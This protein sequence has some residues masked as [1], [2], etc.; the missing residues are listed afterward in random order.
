MVVGQ[1]WLIF[2]VLDKTVTPMNRLID[3]TGVLESSKA[4]VG[5]L[6]SRNQVIERRSLSPAMDR[7]DD[8][9]LMP[10]NLRISC[11][12]CRCFSRAL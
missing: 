11:T 12:L 1:N 8:D 4:L 6:K 9:D 10:R 3:G 2:L 7:S 5:F